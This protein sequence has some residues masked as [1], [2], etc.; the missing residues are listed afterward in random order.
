M[1]L[2]VGASEP[3]LLDGVAAAVWQHLDSEITEADLVQHVAGL[4]GEP[5]GSVRSDVVR[6]L[7]DLADA[8]LAEGPCDP[9]RSC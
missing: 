5:A 4:Y 3:I 2:A 8:G 6:F 9:Q 7:V 1:L